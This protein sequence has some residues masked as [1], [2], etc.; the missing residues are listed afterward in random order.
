M[1][2]KAATRHLDLLA[3]LLV[4]DMVDIGTVLAATQVFQAVPEDQAVVVE[5]L[6]QVLQV[7]AELVQP[8]RELLEAL[9]GLVT[10]MAEV[11]VEQAPLAQMQQVLKEVPAVRAPTGKH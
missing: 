3:R 11:A 5:Q 2:Y 1:E 6:T 7:P 9:L 4:V 10:I 8:V